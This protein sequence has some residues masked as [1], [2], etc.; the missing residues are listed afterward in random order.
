L[1]EN[2]APFGSRCAIH[3]CAVADMDGTAEFG[4]DANWG[5]YG[6]LTANLGHKT[7]VR[8]VHINKILRSV[9][10]KNGHI[11]ILKIDTEGTELALLKAIDSEILKKIGKIYCEASISDPFHPNLFD[12]EQYGTVY[13]LTNK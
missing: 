12:H 13:R 6:G 4:L 10:E 9:L 2:V 3:E 7:S 5:R 11:N 8:C 1:K